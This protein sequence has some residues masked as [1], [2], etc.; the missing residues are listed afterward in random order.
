[1]A[2]FYIIQST[3]ETASKHKE[4]ILRFWNEYLPGTPCERFDWME[5]NPASPTIW[6]L[7]FDTSN[8]ALIGTVSIMIR[9]LALDNKLYRI[10]II[11]DYMIAPKH[12]AFGPALQ[13]QTCAVG[14]MADLG[15][16]FIYGIPNDKSIKSLERI[17]YERLHSLDYFIRPLKTSFYMAKRFG[18][19]TAKV[20]DGVIDRPMKWILSKYITYSSGKA[21]N[22]SLEIDD[23]FE[24]FWEKLK[25]KKTGVLGVRNKS[26]LSWRYLKNPLNTFRFLTCKN[27]DNEL[28]GFAFFT[29]SNSKMEIFD[30]IAL[31]DVHASKLING[32][33]KVALKEDCH[34]IYI[35]LSE[36][37]DMSALLKSHLFIRTTDEV[38]LYAIGN[39]DIYRKKWNFF[40]GDRNI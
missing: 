8:D 38:Q 19:T 32:L 40:E 35:R 4:Q 29:V 36:N 27:N 30:L 16:S 33:I 24:R 31:E 37:N 26:Y 10:G 28:L 14:K 9:E 6:F 23:S 22:E 17:G 12:R 7:A 15:L 21:I 3:T 11:G 1:M 2:G 20:A 5:A 13:L 39:K 34:A 18:N 25:A